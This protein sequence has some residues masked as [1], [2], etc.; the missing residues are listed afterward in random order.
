MPLACGS[1][2]GPFIA[3][4]AHEKTHS[5]FVSLET[6]AGVVDCLDCCSDIF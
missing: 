1:I 3:V 5:L 4:T 6:T 2:Y